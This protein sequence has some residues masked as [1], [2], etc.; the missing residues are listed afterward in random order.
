M[1][2][3]REPML[4]QRGRVTHLAIETHDAI[5]LTI[6]LD[7]APTAPTCQPGQFHM[8]SAFGVHEVPISMSGIRGDRLVEHTIRAEGVATTQL[9]ALQVGDAVGIRG[10]FGS[11]W[12]LAG[13]VRRDVVVMAGGIGLAPLRPL[14][15]AILA[16]RADFGRL[17][18]LIGSRNA[19]ELFYPRDISRWSAGRDVGV[20][21][22]LDQAN[23]EWTGEVGL[24]TQ[25]VDTLDVHPATTRAF[26]CGPEGMMRGSAE[27]LI[28]HGLAADHIELS[29]ERNM[30]CAIGQCGHCQYGPHLI[31]RDGPVLAYHT[32]RRLLEVPDL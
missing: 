4:P 29:M 13:A 15:E 25:L 9:C 30:R 27:S 32:L 19:D 14:I 2:V 10:P 20:A 18:I 22:S 5:T 21:V 12:N 31:C 8:L 11:A 28:E 23:A 24:V 6:A 1:D 3:S 7:G 17:R 26:I 16:S